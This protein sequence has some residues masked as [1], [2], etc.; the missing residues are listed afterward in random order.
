MATIEAT[1]QNF[2]QLVEANGFLILDFWAPWCAPCRAF[3]PVFEQVSEQ[4][5]DIAFA[6][7]NTEQETGLAGHFEI[8]SIPTLMIMRERV[9]VYSQPGSLPLSAL[10]DL[11]DKAAALDMAEIH[12]EISKAAQAPKS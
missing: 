10:K 2:E 7:I 8:R 6:K 9:V 3:G 4:Y 12:R 1:E 11:I 5:P